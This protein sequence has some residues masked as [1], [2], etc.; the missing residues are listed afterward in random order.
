MV[1]STAEDEDDLLSYAFFI[2]CHENPK[3]S[4][5]T[6]Y[7]AMHVHE[8]DVATFERVIDWVTTKTPINRV[9]K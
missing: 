2:H 7:N 3:H 4:L 9:Y 8:L 5:Q 6:V 1:S